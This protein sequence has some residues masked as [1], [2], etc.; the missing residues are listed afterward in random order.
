MDVRPDE[1][2]SP[3][4]LPLVQAPDFQEPILSGLGLFTLVP[5]KAAATSSGVTSS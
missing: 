1:S 3:I 2:D 4:L 5:L